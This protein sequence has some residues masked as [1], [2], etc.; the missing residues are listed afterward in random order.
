MGIDVQLSAAARHWL[1]RRGYDPQF[2]ARPLRRALQ[3]FV[4]NPLSIRLLRGDF[5]P[6]DLVHI[7]EQDGELVFERQAG[8]GADWLTMPQ[9]RV[10][11]D[12]EQGQT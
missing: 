11:Q 8:A 6:G 7:D 5:D 2:G 9:P 4:E 10:D 12:L 1:A 3:R